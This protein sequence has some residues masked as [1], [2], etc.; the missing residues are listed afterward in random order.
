MKTR[1]RKT[2]VIALRVGK[3]FKQILEE[4]SEELDTSVGKLIRDAVMKQYNE[5]F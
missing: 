3:R 1:E 5:K 2:H 4:I